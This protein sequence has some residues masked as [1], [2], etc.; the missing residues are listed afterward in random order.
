MRTLNLDDTELARLATEHLIALGHRN[1]AHI[2]GDI[3]LDM[4]FHL[5]TNRRIGYE[6]A[7]V[8]ADLPVEERYFHAADFTLKEA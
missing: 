8:T 2:G 4:D 1:I 6:H 5:P 7:L 3:E